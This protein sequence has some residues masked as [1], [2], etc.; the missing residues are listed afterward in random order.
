[1]NHTHVLSMAV[2][3]PPAHGIAEGLVFSF[4]V[5]C[6]GQ[7]Q[8]EIVKGDGTD[9]WVA[10]AGWQWCHRIPGISA[11]I[12]VCH[13]SCGGGWVAVESV[14]MDCGR[15][16]GSGGVAVV[17]LD[18]WD[19]CGHFGMFYVVWQAGGFNLTHTLTHTLNTHCHT[20]THTLTH[21]PIATH[22]HPLPLPLLPLPLPHTAHTATPTATHC[23]I[24]CHPSTSTHC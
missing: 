11:V 10:V 6:K 21:T 19:D 8:V 13:T 17:S 15:G 18:S 23:H 5:V 22:C 12:L 14:E 24:H 16:G 1:V 7:W 9:G 4:P 2:P 20:L 3:S